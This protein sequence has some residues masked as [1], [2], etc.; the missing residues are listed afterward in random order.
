VQ[1]IISPPKCLHFPCLRV[2]DPKLLFRIQIL[3]RTCICELD[4]FKH[5]FCV[6]VIS[7][8]SKECQNSFPPHKQRQLWIRDYWNPCKFIFVLFSSFCSAKIRIQIRIC[9]CFTDP[10]IMARTV[11]KNV[12][13][14]V[15][16]TFAAKNH[17]KTNKC[18]PSSSSPFFRQVGS[19]ET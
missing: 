3:L 18:C 16:I 6:K 13:F 15:W 9:K 7:A 10:S 4:N 11:V 19:R 1:K 17:K 5:Y 14:A 12:V 8:R 2:A